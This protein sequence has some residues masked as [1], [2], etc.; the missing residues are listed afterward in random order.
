MS[1][2]DP[3]LRGPVPDVPALLQPVA[4]ALV[5]AREDV[6]RAVAELRPED[7]WVGPGTAASPGFHLKHL[8]GA[9]ERL[10]AYARGEPLSEAQRE[11]LR[12]EQD[13]G[14]PD[15]TPAALEAAFAQV[16]EAGLAQLANTPIEYL[17]TQ[18]L[19]GRSQLPTTVLGCLAH[20]GEHAARHAGQLVTTVRALRAQGP[21]ATTRE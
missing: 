14:P 18:R 9:T 11:W 8:V 1:K 3:W 13:P 12:A 16:V 6:E 4:H 10:L 19:I 21:A 17:T 7:L 5:Q 20:A 2:P 15:Q